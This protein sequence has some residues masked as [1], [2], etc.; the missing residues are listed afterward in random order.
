MDSDGV[1][2]ADVSL[3]GLSGKLCGRKYQFLLD[4]GASCNFV[5]QEFLVKL[6]IDWDLVISQPVQLADKTVLKTSGK[7]DLKIA[8]G[9]FTYFGTFYVL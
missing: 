2:D 1:A 6:G 5:S 3:I 9:P 4:S 7:V 8:F